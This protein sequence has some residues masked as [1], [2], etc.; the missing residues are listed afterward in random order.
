MNAVN[1]ANETGNGNAIL[2]SFWEVSL[3]WE[4]W[5]KTK[6]C[7]LNESY[8]TDLGGFVKSRGTL[9]FERFDSNRGQ[10]FKKEVELGPGYLADVRHACVN[11]NRGENKKERKSTP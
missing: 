10:W 4:R 2:N 5:S 1:T 6:Y 8:I 9:L 3:D 7:P 11:A